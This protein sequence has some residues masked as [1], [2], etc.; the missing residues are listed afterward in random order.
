MKRRLMGAGLGVVLAVGLV[1]PTV[2]Q[3]AETSVTAATAPCANNVGS[4][5]SAGAHTGRGVTA[6]TPPSAGP[7][8]TTTGVYGAGKV[9]L[10]SHFED[11]P[12]SGAGS[13]MSGYVVIGDALYYSGY[14]TNGSG[15]VEPPGPQLTRIGRGWSNFTLLDWATYDTVEAG[16]VTRTELYA[17]RK[18]GVLFR[19]HWTG[20]G[21]RA[22]GSYPGFSAVKTMAVISKRPTYDTFL[23]T[24]KGGALY[25]IR[26]PTALPMKP[27]VKQVRARTWQGFETLI[28]HKCGQYGTLLLGID[29]DTQSGYLYAVGHANGTSTV[30]NSLGKVANATFA[31][32]ID[33]RWSIVAF[34]DVLNGE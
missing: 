17:L 23:A 28:A 1:P 2:G 3:A 24:T 12:K 32:P 20:K 27:V 6:A 7:L 33:F 4:V 29:K 8:R 21:W 10:T 18:D 26:I 25:T 13:V 9:R 30:L 22:T 5:T 31:D 19:W 15:Q 14:T 11:Y 16:D 34:Y